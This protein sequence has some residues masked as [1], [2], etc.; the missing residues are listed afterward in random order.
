[1]NSI[2]NQYINNQKDL[3]AIELFT[4]QNTM[5][6]WVNASAVASWMNKTNN[7]TGK[8]IHHASML[9]DDLSTMDIFGDTKDGILEKKTEVITYIRHGKKMER[10]MPVYRLI[11]ADLIKPAASQT[12]RQSLTAALEE[13]EDKLEARCQRTFELADDLPF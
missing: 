4:S 3:S 6:C 10:M 1:M 13:A 5:N 2:L 8:Q 7:P 11:D 9:L 12:V